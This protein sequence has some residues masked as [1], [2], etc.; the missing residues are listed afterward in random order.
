[1]KIV[2]VVQK[3]VLKELTRAMRIWYTGC[4]KRPRNEMPL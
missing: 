4:Q 3:A 2:A 1:M